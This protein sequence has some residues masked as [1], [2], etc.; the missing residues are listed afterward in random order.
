MI[1]VRTHMPSG[2]INTVTF[3]INLYALWLSEY[4]H[5]RDT[6]AMTSDN[7]NTVSRYISPYAQWLSHYVRPFAILIQ[8][9]KL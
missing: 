2:N 6:C 7:I 9:L 3:K 4:S 8:S 5:N 1:N